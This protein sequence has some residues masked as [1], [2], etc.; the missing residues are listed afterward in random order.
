MKTERFAWRS[1]TRRLGTAITKALTTRGVSNAE[2]VGKGHF[3]GPPEDGIIYHF[4]RLLNQPSVL[5]CMFIVCCQS[6]PNN[7]LFCKK[8]FIYTVL[9][10]CESDRMV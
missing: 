9:R 5:F 2:E 3:V 8:K 1:C 10:K 6:A 4:H 7:A